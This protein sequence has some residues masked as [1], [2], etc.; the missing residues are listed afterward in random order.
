MPVQAIDA[1]EAARADYRHLNRIRPDRRIGGI[2]TA[3]VGASRPEAVQ[4]EPVLRS[5]RRC[6]SQLHCAVTL[7]YLQWDPA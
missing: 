7:S 2:E 4:R 1:L 5:L 6:L 3:S